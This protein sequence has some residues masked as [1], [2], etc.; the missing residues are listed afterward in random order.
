MK[1]KTG[2]IYK[3]FK[4]GTVKVIDIATH[5]ETLERYVVYEALYD[6]RT[7]GYGSI[8]IRPLSMFVENVEFEGK[9][10]PR[11]ELNEVKK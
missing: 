6:C 9:I 7:N 8:W 10:V 4:G 2:R 3:H 11:F 1:T 5:S